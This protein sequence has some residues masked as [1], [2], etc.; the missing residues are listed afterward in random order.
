MQNIHTLQ[1]E[2]ILNTRIKLFFTQISQNK[3]ELEAN[4]ISD[5]E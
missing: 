2:N 5:S 3:K 1:F 4:K